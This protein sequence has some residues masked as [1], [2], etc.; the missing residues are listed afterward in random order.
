MF[1][2]TAFTVCHDMQKILTDMS[3]IKQFQ[4]IYTLFIL[5]RVDISEA[6]WPQSG[7]PCSLFLFSGFIIMVVFISSNTDEFAVIL[8]YFL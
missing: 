6:H 8:P 5:F 2:I 4:N 7:E 3:F 1:G